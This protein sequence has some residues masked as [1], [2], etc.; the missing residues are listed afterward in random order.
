V[1]VGGLGEETCRPKPDTLLKRLISE[2]PPKVS[3][4]NLMRQNCTGEVGKI[5]P[6]RQA[7]TIVVLDFA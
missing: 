4:P 3:V 7:I 5:E 1:L 6:M 2:P